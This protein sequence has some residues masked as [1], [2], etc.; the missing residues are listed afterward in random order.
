[1]FTL[2]NL[3][4]AGLPASSTDGNGADA[5]THFT[6]ELTAPEWRVYLSIADPQRAR[7]E[8]AEGAVR[9]IPG[10][11]TWNEA[12]ALA[13]LNNNLSDAQVDLV[14]NLAD[15]RALMKKQ[16]TAIKAMAQMLIALRNHSFPGLEDEG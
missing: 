13:W 6:R 9:N 1:M 5:I 7:Q 14:A 3:L 16:N 12:E 11:A 2:Q 8:G 4:D 15:A 10:W